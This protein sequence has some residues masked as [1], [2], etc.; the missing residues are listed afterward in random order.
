MPCPSVTEALSR[1]GA[2]ISVAAGRD[3]QFSS[4][5]DSSKQLIY[6]DRNL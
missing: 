3:E 1:K 2:V 5:C 4:A 6:P